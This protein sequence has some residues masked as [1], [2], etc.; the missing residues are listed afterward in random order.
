MEGDAALRGLWLPLPSMLTETEGRERGP[1]AAG[2]LCGGLSG[3]I[4]VPA[5]LT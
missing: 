4:V 5:V 1:V 2:V 3:E